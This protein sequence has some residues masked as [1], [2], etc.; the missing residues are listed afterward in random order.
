[1]LRSVA[2]EIVG[3]SN[4][5]LIE[6]RR[7]GHQ[8]G[9][10]ASAAAAS[11]AGALPGSGDG[12]GVAR[13]D[14]GIQRAHIDAELEG[15]GGNDAADFPVAESALNFAALVRKVAATVAANGFWFSRML[16]IRL[17]QIGEKNF[18]VQARIGEDDGLQ[19]AFQKFLRDARGFIDVAAANG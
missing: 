4:D 9:T 14:D 3:M 17:L 10:R 1:M 2:E 7:G 16:R 5:E 12:A 8:H 19:I 18:R 15:A 11:T 13:H 6:R